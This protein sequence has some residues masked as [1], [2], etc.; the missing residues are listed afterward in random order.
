MFL[1]DMT[2]IRSPYLSPPVCSGL[3][4]KYFPLLHIPLLHRRFQPLPYSS[5]LLF[6]RWFSY[7]G[8]PYPHIRPSTIKH[9]LLIGHPQH[10]LYHIL[11]ASYLHMLPPDTIHTAFNG[12]NKH[13]H[14]IILTS[15]DYSPKAS[16]ITAAANKTPDNIS[17]SPPFTFYKFSKS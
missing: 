9:K 8:S 13:P 2:S 3:S 4:K 12:Q 10:L 16:N 11:N 14:P 5:H 17:A 15:F 6:A 7:R 1:M